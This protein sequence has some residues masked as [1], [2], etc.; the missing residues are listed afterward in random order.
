LFEPAWSDAPS[1]DETFALA[2]DL[3]RC[4]AATK[5]LL[6]QLPL[7]AGWV[8]RLEQRY[9]DPSLPYHGGAHVGLLWLRHLAHGGP[10]HDLGIALAIMF[11]D[12][13]YRPGRPDNEARSADLLR[14]AARPGCDEVDWAAQAILATADHAAYAGADRRIMWLLDLDLTPLAE[15]PDIFD[16]N[17]A[18]LQAEV[19]AARRAAWTRRQRVLLSRLLHD[20]PLFRSQLSHTYEAAARTNLLRFCAEPS[21]SPRS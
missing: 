7:D 11:H 13:V 21:G 6:G 14:E 10:V 4:E 18:D 16:R 9:R 15:R 17:L 12:A 3:T 19:S 20:P 8:E 5:C 2:A 1:S